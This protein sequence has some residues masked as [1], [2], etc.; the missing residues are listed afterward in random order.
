MDLSIS[1]RC[2][3]ATEPLADMLTEGAFTTIQWESVC[4]FRHSST[5]T[6]RVNRSIS[7]TFSSAVTALSAHATS[8]A[9]CS[10][11]DFEVGSWDERLEEPQFGLAN[12]RSAWMKPTRSSENK[13]ARTS[14][15]LEKEVC[16][17]NKARKTNVTEEG[18]VAL[19]ERSGVTTLH[20][21]PSRCR[22]EL[23]EGS[24][25]V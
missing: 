7:E 11:R 17:E 8:N 9:Y 5:T 4:H 14:T 24:D 20:S 2:V 16:Q 13:K 12:Q 15:V 23:G 1:I 19:W 22:E 3:R 10:Q 6:T 21:R 18:F 25:G